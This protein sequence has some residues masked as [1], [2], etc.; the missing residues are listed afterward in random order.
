M[1]LTDPMVSRMAAETLSHTFRIVRMRASLRTQG[2]KDLSD[3]QHAA[4][5]AF[6]ETKS[7]A[8]PAATAANDE[9]QLAAGV[10]P[11]SVESELDKAKEVPR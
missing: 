10:L 1:C 4:M 5:K 7:F 11:D 2:E 3:E 9:A 8:L 6:I